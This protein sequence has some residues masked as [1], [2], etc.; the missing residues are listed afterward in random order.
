[1]IGSVRDAYRLVFGALIVLLLVCIGA[2]AVLLSPVGRSR[3]SRQAEYENVREQLMQKRREALPSRDMGQKLVAARQQI[4]GFYSDRLPAR[5]ST[6]SE[7]IGE[8]AGQNRVQIVSMQY[9]SEDAPVAGLER[10]NIDV[11]ISGQYEQEMKL[12]NALERDKTFF[13]INSV[14]LG[15]A[16]GGAVQL[17]LRLETYIRTGARA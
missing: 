2:V 1:M 11:A 14:E 9:K 3:E 12:V 7:T 4:D 8:L 10:V 17:K 6:I 13:V 15:A 5:Y 16:Q